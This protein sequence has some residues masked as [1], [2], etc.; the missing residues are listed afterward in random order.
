MVTVQINEKAKNAKQFLEFVKTL[1]FAKIEND[2]YN[3]EFVNRILKADKGKT[4][5]ITAKTVWE[6]IK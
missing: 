6:D 1:P 3:P 5:R 4:L 2:I